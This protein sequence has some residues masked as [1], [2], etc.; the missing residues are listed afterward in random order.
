MPEPISHV[1]PA[2]LLLT[3]GGARAAYQVGVLE[4]IADIRLACGAG[5]EPNPFPIIT[6][7]SAGAINASALACGSDNFDATVRLIAETWRGF[8]ADQV[9]RTGHLSML[10]SGATWLTLLSMGW[11]LAK[12]RRVKPRS[13]LDNAP[14]AELLTRLV[15]LERL[16]DL[17]RQGHMQALAVTASSYSSGEHVTFYEGD[18]RLLPWIRSQRLAVQDKITHAHLLAS[19]AIPFVFPATELHINGHMEYFGDG[20]M[21]QSAPCSPA[22]HLG[23]DRILVVGAGRM[24][25][26]KNQQMPLAAAAYPSIAQIAGHALSNIF[27]DALAVD[28]ERAQRINQTIKLVPEAARQASALRPLEL[29]VISPSERID[30]IASKHIDALPHAVRTML[31]GVGVS[32]RKAD[33]KGSALASYLLFETGYTSELMALGYADA[34]RQRL[35]ICGFFNWTD[36]EAVC[37][38][39]D[40]SSR[41]PTGVDRRRDP[42]RLR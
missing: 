22:I 41:L 20:S 34:Q 30:M 36:P 24:H 42:L 16:P 18:K 5:N 9:Y 35:E 3:G 37:L 21:R 26:P 7:T 31:G 38:L 2:G 10:R 40:K 25:E 39:D 11:I 19:S 17:I 14:L 15:P 32:S 1:R 8:H 13:L 29:L 4:A 27:L 33:V 6:G 28:V 12:W 23:A